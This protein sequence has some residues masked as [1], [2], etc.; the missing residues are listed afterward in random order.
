METGRGVPP[1]FRQLA[2]PTQWI[3]SV[4]VLSGLDKLD[5]PPSVMTLRT[6]VAQRLPRME[7]PELLLE[8]QAWTGLAS[9]FTR[10]NE[11][12]A[13]ADDLPISVGAHYWPRRESPPRA[14]GAAR[15]ASTHTRSTGV[16]S[17]KLTARRHDH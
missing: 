3:S 9:D 11:Y 10:V 12:G 17:A 7:L 1:H 6:V 4:S 15:G 13:R 8:V 2:Q 16:D 5:E 14:V